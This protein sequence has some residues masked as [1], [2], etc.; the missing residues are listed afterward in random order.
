MRMS[1]MFPFAAVIVMLAGFVL[2]YVLAALALSAII[3][4]LNWRR[5]SVPLAIA[6]LILAIATLVIGSWVAY[7][8]G[9]VR[10]K[11]FRFEPP[12]PPRK[13]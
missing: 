1:R 11:E 2:F 3:A 6:T 13:P 9:H 4:P 10:H 5:G 7:P 8:G 12:P